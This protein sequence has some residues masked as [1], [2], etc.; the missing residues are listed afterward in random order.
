MLVLDYFSNLTDLFSAF[1]KFKILGFPIIFIFIHFCAVFQT[2]DK[3]DCYTTTAN[4]T[5]HVGWINEAIGVINYPK[6]IQQLQ[7]LPVESGI[8]NKN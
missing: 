3:D 5:T 7:I 1:D 2:L 6:H 8:K 4:S